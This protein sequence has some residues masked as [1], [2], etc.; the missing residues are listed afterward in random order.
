MWKVVRSG[1]GGCVTSSARRSAPKWQKYRP[2]C[3]SIIAFWR[4]RVQSGR[5]YHRSLG[6]SL[7]RSV[8]DF[9]INA[10]KG[11]G[12]NKRPECEN[13]QVRQEIWCLRRERTRKCEPDAR[14]RTNG[15]LNFRRSCRPCC[16]GGLLASRTWAFVVVT[17]WIGSWT[18]G[19]RLQCRSLKRCWT[20]CIRIPL[21]RHPVDSPTLEN[22]MFIEVIGR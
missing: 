11:G 8:T 18:T 6:C 10:A 21:T 20:S 15:K 5:L 7:A 16:E 1:V 14:H 17:F 3:G 19:D 9:H 13:V 12:D 4:H 22:K 2:L